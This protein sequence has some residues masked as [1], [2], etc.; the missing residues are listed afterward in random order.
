MR[1]TTEEE[2]ALEQRWQNATLAEIVDHIVYTFHE[3]LRTEL[4]RLESI[5]RD[6]RDASAGETVSE[7]LLT[8]LNLRGE[9]ED[10]MA[11]EEEIL[12]PMIRRG[13]GIMADGPIR[14]MEDEHEG[15]VAALRRLRELAGGYRLS[16]DDQD[17][18]RAALWQGLAA[19][20]K[21]MHEHIYL[22]ND[23]LFPRALEG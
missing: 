16:D 14:M 1:M 10:H 19:L 8:F 3:P 2:T 7:L 18:P 17:G 4:P 20:E 9:L 23:I 12:F 13:D 21:I 22:E 5:A 15:A 11:K 6:L